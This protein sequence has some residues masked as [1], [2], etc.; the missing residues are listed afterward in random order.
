M[1]GWVSLFGLM[2]VVAVLVHQIWSAYYLGVGAMCLLLG[3]A[4][5]LIIRPSN[6]PGWR[7]AT[8][9]VD[10][11]A[12][13]AAGMALMGVSLI[14]IFILVGRNAGLT[15]AL[16]EVGALIAMIASAVVFVRLRRRSHPTDQ[17]SH[18]ADV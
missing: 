12:K 14:V 17:Q 15:T 18:D 3:G 5:T 6:D 16:I 8:Y 10:T 13:R 7:G 11:P 4:L 2:A 9:K 1:L